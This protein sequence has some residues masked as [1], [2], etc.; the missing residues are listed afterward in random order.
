MSNNVV[1]PPAFFGTRIAYMCETAFVHELEGTEVTVYDTLE[2]YER[3]HGCDEPIFEV[4]ICVKKIHPPR[5]NK[6]KYERL[7]K[8]LG[9]EDKSDG[10]V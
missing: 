3:R 2:S 5:H 10:Q 6:E 8:E 4:E 1:R 9:I 7:A